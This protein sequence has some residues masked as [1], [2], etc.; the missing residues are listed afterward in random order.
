MHDMAAGVGV[1]ELNIPK[2]NLDDFG[3]SEIS[4]SVLDGLYPILEMNE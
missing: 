3:N 4:P 2:L 1:K